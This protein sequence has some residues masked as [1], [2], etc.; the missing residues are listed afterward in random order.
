[1]KNEKLPDL[2]Q[3]LV[4]LGFELYSI[5]EGDNNTAAIP[6]SAFDQ[7][8]QKMNLSRPYA[9]IAHQFL[10]EVCII[11]SFFFIVVYLLFRMVQNHWMLIKLI[12]L[13]EQ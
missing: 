5:K 9:L 12:Q 1:M 6:A 10:T 7:L 2:V 3:D 4:N 11:Y 8:F 13:Y